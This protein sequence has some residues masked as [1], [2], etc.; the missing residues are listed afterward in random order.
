MVG[1]QAKN[2]FA[3]RGII[4]EGGLKVDLTKMMDQK[5][6]NVSALTGGIEGLFKKNKVDYVKGMGKLTSTTSVEV[7]LSDGG[8]QTLKTKN[9]MLATGSEV[10]SSSSSRL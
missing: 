6:K 10:S 8:T 3:S 1:R 5:T 2:D 4:I 9:I 7:Q